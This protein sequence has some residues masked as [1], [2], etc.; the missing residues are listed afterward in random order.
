VAAG[1]IVGT[2]GHLSRGD[3]RRLPTRRVRG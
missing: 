1:Q 2:I 3:D